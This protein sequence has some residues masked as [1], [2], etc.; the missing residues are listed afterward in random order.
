M[1]ALNQ[2]KKVILLGE[3][4]TT[5]FDDTTIT[6]EAVYSDNITKLGIFTTI[7]I[8]CECRDVHLVVKNVI[9]NENGIMISV[10]MKMKKIHRVSEAD[11][12]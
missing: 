6:V 11:Y 12:A 10:N 2:R 8:S 4:P 7:H 3:G 1:R 9:Q 5:G